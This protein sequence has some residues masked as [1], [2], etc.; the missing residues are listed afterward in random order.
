MFRSAGRGM[1]LGVYTDAEALRRAVS[2]E[3]RKEIALDTVQP[4]PTQELKP[5]QA[6]GMRIQGN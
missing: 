3:P 6:L 1:T 4:R 2:R 5:R